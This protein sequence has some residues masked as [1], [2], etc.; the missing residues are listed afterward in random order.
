MSKDWD[1]ASQKRNVL[2]NKIGCL[3]CNSAFKVTV[4]AWQWGIYCNSCLCSSPAASVWVRLVQSAPLGICDSQG[5]KLKGLLII[6]FRTIFQLTYCQVLLRFQQ[7]RLDGLAYRPALN[8]EHQ[9]WG[10]VEGRK[11]ARYCHLTT[12]FEFSPPIIITPRKAKFWNL[13]S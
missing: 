13:R 9:S 12:S 2:W 1:Q 11:R 3:V 10:R 5:I 4:F 7:I 8:E 6:H